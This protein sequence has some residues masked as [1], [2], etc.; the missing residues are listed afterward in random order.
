MMI[1]TAGPH[2]RFSAAGRVATNQRFPG[3]QFL[4]K[5]ADRGGLR[6]VAAIVQFEDR[7]LTCRVRVSLWRAPVF[8]AQEID[9]HRL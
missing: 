6:E 9:F 7:R 2:A 1:S 4:E 5:L 8:A 3:V